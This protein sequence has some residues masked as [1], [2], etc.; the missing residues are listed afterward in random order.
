MDTE[1][2][3]TVTLRVEPEALRSIISA[4][5]LLEFADTVADQ[6]ATQIAAQLV[7]CAAES[8]VDPQGLASEAGAE[9]SYR[10]V[11]GEGEPGFGTKPRPPRLGVVARDRGPAALRQFEGDVGA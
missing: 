9:I 7:Q 6:A 10:V 11:A 8:T 4:G 2:I 1:H 5:R 3:A